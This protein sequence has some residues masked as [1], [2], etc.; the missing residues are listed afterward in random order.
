MD[1]SRF[2]TQRRNPFTG[3]EYAQGHI[4]QFRGMEWTAERA[5]YN[6]IERT[7]REV[8]AVGGYYYE[9]TRTA[10]AEPVPEVREAP[11]RLQRDVF[12]QPQPA[13]PFGWTSG[14]L[15]RFARPALHERERT[16]SGRCV[17]GPNEGEVLS[18]RSP[19][20]RTV[21][22][23]EITTMYPAGDTQIATAN[24]YTYEWRGGTVGQWA[25]DAVSARRWRERNAR[26]R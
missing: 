7:I 9:V 21:D 26:P 19:Y 14:E 23:P 1:L 3:V 5:E 2:V 6:A 16:Y 11:V 18:S 10:G 24:I 4:G 15:Q 25:L 13:P 12:A 22:L 17:D 8:E 20:I